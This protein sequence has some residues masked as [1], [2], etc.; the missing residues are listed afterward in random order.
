MLTSRNPNFSL[1]A[2]P[3]ARPPIQVSDAKE[4]NAA[5]SMEASDSAS[6]VQ[7]TAEGN[8][9]ATANPLHA[10]GE[11]VIETSLLANPLPTPKPPPDVPKFS[12]RICMCGRTLAGKSEQ[13]IRLA[14]RYCLKVSSP[15]RFLSIR[16]YLLSRAM[17]FK[18][19]DD[20]FF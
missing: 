1:P 7:V 13:A 14:D 2:R 10:L 18:G 12:L 6:N 11:C 19:V 3:P 16:H 17:F 5:K 4:E 9:L 20:N 8:F 15:P